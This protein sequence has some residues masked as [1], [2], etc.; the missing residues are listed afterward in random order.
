MLFIINPLRP[1]GSP[2][3]CQKK[4]K[5]KQKNDS[6]YSAKPRERTF[7]PSAVI[8]VVALGLTYASTPSFIISSP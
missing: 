7:V 1:S 8:K 4:K 2:Q 3:T 5:D 6:V